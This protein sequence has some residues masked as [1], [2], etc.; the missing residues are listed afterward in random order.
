MTCKLCQGNGYVVDKKDVR[1]FLDLEYLCFE[2]NKRDV[3]GQGV[4]KIKFCPMC[5]R[6]LKEQAHDQTAD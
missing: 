3:G 1:V 2:Y 6:R 4:K 5:G